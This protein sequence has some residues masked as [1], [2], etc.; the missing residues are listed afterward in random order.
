[1][2]ERLTHQTEVNPRLTAALERRISASA[3]GYWCSVQVGCTG[4][5]LKLQAGK[6]TQPCSPATAHEKAVLG[7][8]CGKWGRPKTRER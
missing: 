2:V 1:M 6:L 7:P 8:I 4:F 5:S 3:R